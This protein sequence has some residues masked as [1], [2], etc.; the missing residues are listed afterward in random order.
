MRFSIVLRLTSPSK[1]RKCQLLSSPSLTGS[2][3]AGCELLYRCINRSTPLPQLNDVEPPFASLAFADEGLCYVQA[4][5]NGDLRQASLF[6]SPSKEL[7]E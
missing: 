6:S 1:Q 5:C 7:K 2:I 3:K 4:L